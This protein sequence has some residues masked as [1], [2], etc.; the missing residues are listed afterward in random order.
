MERISYKGITIVML[1]LVALLSIAH[2]I[3]T[4]LQFRDVALRAQAASLS[5]VIGVASDE[6]LKL[7]HDNAF[8]LV[9]DLQPRL[10][11]ANRRLHSRETLRAEMDDLFVNGF[12]GA[13]GLDLVKLRIYDTDLRLV[14]QSSLGLN[15]LPQAAPHFLL[16]QAL[17]RKGA[18]RLKTIGGLWQAPERALYSLLAPIGGL[19]ISGYVE[20]VLDPVYNLTGI[21]AMTKLPIRIVTLNE[22]PLFASPSLNDIKASEMLQVEYLLRD[23]RGQTL[24]RVLAYENTSNFYTDLQATQSNSTVTVIVVILAVLLLAL[25]LLN[26]LLFIPV[27]NLINGVQSCM[28]GKLETSTIKA[29]GVKEVHLLAKAF[30]TMANTLLEHMNTLQRLSSLDGLTGIANRR[31]FDAQMEQEWT[32]ALRNRTPLALLLIDIDSFK[33]YNDALGHQAGDNCLREV[34]TVLQN[35]MKR[36]GDM[37]ARYGGEEFAIILPD[38]DIFGAGVV[39]LNIRNALQSRGIPHPASPIASI[40][41][42]SIGINIVIPKSM[43]TIL[44]FIGGADRALYRVKHNGRNNVCF[45]EEAAQEPRSGDPDGMSQH[46]H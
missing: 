34:A 4:K 7:L 37:V 20:V 8:N 14:A 31:A 13:G 43:D 39:A 33:A 16:E 12:A 9:G 24:Y 17:P 19:R 36:P 10:V 40:I 23:D 26:R 32:R 41:T 1:L 38:T 5:R 3:N 11:D 28:D 45:A 44:H 30:N 25:Y 6:T 27:N 21:S 2:T 35:E 42:F 46:N 29:E 15:N 22:Q 18:D